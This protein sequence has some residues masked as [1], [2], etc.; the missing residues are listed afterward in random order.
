MVLSGT[1]SRLEDVHL[2]YYECVVSIRTAPALWKRLSS[3]QRHVPPSDD[4]WSSQSLQEVLLPLVKI[5]AVSLPMD[6][7][8]VRSFD[9]YC[10]LL[11]WDT[12][13]QMFRC[14]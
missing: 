5:S 4:E 6:V 11:D 1:T 13:C 14:T 10:Q 9:T 2:W 7:E 3:L 8:A 12:L